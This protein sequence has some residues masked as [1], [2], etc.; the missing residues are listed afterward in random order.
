MTMTFRRT[1]LAI[2]ITTGLV[3]VG[4]LGGV[5]IDRMRFDR[6]RMTVLK[7]YEDALMRRNQTL[8]KLELAT[9]GRHPA[10]DAQWRQALQDIDDAWQTANPGRAVAAW[11]DAYRAAVR[12]GRWDAMIDVGDAALR[13]GPV[14][15]FRDA[16][17]AMA[18]R[19]YLIALFRARAQA[20]LDGVLRAC[21]GFAL[22]GDLPV[23]KQCIGIGHE[24]A[25][26]DPA[27]DRRV[28]AFAN[29]FES[30]PAVAV[31][32]ATATPGL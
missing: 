20:S 11:H 30:H 13:V 15:E 27:A 12:T 6:H 22:L 16:P 9:N 5:V 7:P 4:V 26:T 19:S 25:K 23:V 24:L 29:Q 17:D 2:S 31:E 28:V 14:S 10:F 18:R 32:Y 3:A 1:A 8:M 21:E